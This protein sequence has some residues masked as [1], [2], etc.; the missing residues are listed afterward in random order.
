MRCSAAITRDETTDTEAVSAC[1]LASPML[2]RVFGLLALAALPA[3]LFF[4]PFFFGLAGAL[5]AV[6]SLLLAPAG[7]RL[8]GA[9]GLLAAATVGALAVLPRW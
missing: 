8:L 3:A 7:C 4:K 1:P 2:S 9:L 6:L 5:L